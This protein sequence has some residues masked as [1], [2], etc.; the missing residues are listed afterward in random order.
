M[1]SAELLRRIDLDDSEYCFLRLEG[2]PGFSGWLL[3]MNFLRKYY[4]VFDFGRK[5]LGFAE[6]RAKSST[7]CQADSSYSVREFPD[8]A[9]PIASNTPWSTSPSQSPSYY[10]PTPHY[11]SPPSNDAFVA[12]TGVL[13]FIILVIVF[14][15]IGVAIGACRALT[16]VLRWVQ[17]PFMRV[18]TKYPDEAVG[19]TRELELSA[20][21]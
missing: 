19:N 3:G 17:V 2:V 6:A 7:R 9:K 12:L 14:F 20:I 15:F 10:S 13:I 21:T 1:T 5:R 4:T 16:H 18:R 11:A 8:G